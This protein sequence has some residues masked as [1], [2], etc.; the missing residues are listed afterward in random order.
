MLTANGM[1]KIVVLVDCT[2]L[3]MLSHLFLTLLTGMIQKYDKMFLGKYD[4]L[5]YSQILLDICLYRI[6]ETIKHVMY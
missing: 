2:L 4:L 3:K 1:P 5:F 6:P